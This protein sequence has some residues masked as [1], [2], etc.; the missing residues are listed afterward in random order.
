MIARQDLPSSQNVT[1]IALHGV[2][3]T[4]RQ[5]QQ[6]YVCA[7]YQQPYVSGYIRCVWLSMSYAYMAWCIAPQT[8]S[9]SD[10]A[11]SNQTTSIKQKQLHM[12]KTDTQ[13]S[14]KILSAVSLSTKRDMIN[15]IHKNY[16]FT[17]G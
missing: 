1:V 17:R 7:T 13:T 2:C 16:T 12:S 9:A 15:L 14:K 4:K 10:Y 5:Q 11:N 3:A 6:P 8:R